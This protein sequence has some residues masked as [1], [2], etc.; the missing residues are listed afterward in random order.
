MCGRGDQSL[1][2][3]DICEL[4]G[5]IGMTPT[6][7]LEPVYNVAPTTTVHTVREVGGERVIEKARP[8]PS[9]L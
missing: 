6:S 9:C 8:K 2:W 1:T 4:S 5:I 7:N 3:A